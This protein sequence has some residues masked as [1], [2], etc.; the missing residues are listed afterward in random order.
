MKTHW[1]WFLPTELDAITELI[2]PKKAMEPTD[3]DLGVM[4]DELRRMYTLWQTYAKE[5]S[6]LDMEA[7]YQNPTPERQA[8]IAIAKFK[9]S[10]RQEAM[11]SNFWLSVR[12]EFALWSNLI[13]GARSGWHI[14]K[15]TQPEGMPPFLRQ[16]FH[17]Q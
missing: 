2:E 12:D 13:I 5:Q 3:E 7:Q 8:E 17:L 1:I 4:S 10:C 15:M 14:V 11:S 16:L 6:E 9:A